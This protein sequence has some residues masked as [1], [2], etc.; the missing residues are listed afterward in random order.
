MAADANSLGDLHTLL[1]EVMSSEIQAYRA[2][3]VPVPA[4][5]MAAVAKFLKDNNITCDPVDADAIEELR[6]EFEAQSIA[7]R[8]AAVEAAGLAVDDLEALY[9]TH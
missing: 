8:S 1:T 5:V 3:N 7:R 9:Q 6:A 2:N 4:S